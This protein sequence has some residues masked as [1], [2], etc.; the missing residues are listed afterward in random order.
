MCSLKVK[1][2]ETDPAGCSN[3]RPVKRFTKYNYE[4][5]AMIGERTQIV[6]LIPAFLICLSKKEN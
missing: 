5:V 6:I 2:P 4:P 1:Y 3:L